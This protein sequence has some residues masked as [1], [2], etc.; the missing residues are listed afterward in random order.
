MNLST[1][2]LLFLWNLDTEIKINKYIRSCIIEKHENTKITP[3]KI[4]FHTG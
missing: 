2:H 4:S 3:S 1:V